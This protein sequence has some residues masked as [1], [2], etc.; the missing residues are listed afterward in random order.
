MH[1]GIQGRLALICSEIGSMWR[2]SENCEC[3]MCFIIACTVGVRLQGIVVMR[4]DLEE[5]TYCVGYGIEALLAIL[6]ECCG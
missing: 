5:L 6:G 4:R 1:A 2:S 3:G